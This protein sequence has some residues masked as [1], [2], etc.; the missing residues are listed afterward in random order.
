MLRACKNNKLMAV[1]KQGRQQL[2]EQLAQERAQSSQRSPGGW[3][4]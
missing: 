2:E 3:D 4:A 1:I